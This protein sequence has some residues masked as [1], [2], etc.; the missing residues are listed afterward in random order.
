M[1]P[2]SAP[3]APSVPAD[4]IERRIAALRD[5][6]RDAGLAG[7]LLV[8]MTDLYYFSGTV[9]DAHLLVPADGAPIL[10]VRRSLLRAEMESAIG[11]VR[12]IRSLRELASALD[13]A[14]VSGERLGLEL[15]VLPVARLQR[16][17]E[18]LASTAMADCSPMRCPL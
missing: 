14:G 4:E 7:A 1:L 5:G 3:V 11:D 12:S 2:N 18:L 17:Q 9:Q 13:A 8:E 6:L 16:Y 10:L 15:D